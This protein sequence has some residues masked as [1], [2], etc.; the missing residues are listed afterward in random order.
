[1]VLE[2]GGFECNATCSAEEVVEC[3]TAS[4]RAYDIFILC[5]SIP[6][7]EQELILKAS[8]GCHVKLYVLTHL[9]DPFEFIERVRELAADC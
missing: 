8:E 2:K 5:H 4:E 3:I 1:M 7:H 9:T 6:F